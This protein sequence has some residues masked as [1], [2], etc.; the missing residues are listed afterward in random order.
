[1]FAGTGLR[2][3][4]LLG[5]HHGVVGYETVGCRITFDEYQLPVAAGGDD[6]PDDVDVVAFAP[7]SWWYVRGPAARP[8]WSLRSTGAAPVMSSRRCQRGRQQIVLGRGA[9][10]GEGAEVLGPHRLARS[11]QQGERRPVGVAPRAGPGAAEHA[12]V[13]PTIGTGASVRCSR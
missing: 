12:A 9:L 11:L 5:A 3:G 8:P 10:V 6:T 4:D 7:S 2:Y 13:G 1:M